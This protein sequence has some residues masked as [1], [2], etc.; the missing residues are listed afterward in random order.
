MN[1]K[2]ANSNRKS[3]PHTPRFTGR[4]PSR[5][6]LEPVA[7]WEAEVKV[8]K[9]GKAHAGMK[10]KVLTRGVI[11]FKASSVLNSM[12]DALLAGY[13][14][15]LVDGAGDDAVRFFPCLDA[16]YEEMFVAAQTMGN[17]RKVISDI[18]FHL[19]HRGKKVNQYDY[20][21][22]KIRRQWEI[23]K[24]REK[25]AVTPDTMVTCPNCGTEF[26]VGR[27]LEEN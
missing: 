10:R 22:E 15:R 3:K 14:V 11:K 17:F 27:K 26:R 9:D 7:E 12:M 6:R 25:L 18:R 21:E 13:E 19:E 8:R 23:E 24:K 2:K 4:N 20:L 1:T 5:E 16:N